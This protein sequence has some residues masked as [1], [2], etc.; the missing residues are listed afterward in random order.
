MKKIKLLLFTIIIFI[1]IFSCGEPPVNMPETNLIDLIKKNLDLLNEVKN[2]VQKSINYFKELTNNFNALIAFYKDSTITTS[3]DEALPNKED[4]LYTLKDNKFLVRR[5]LYVTF[6]DK[7]TLYSFDKIIWYSNRSDANKEIEGVKNDYYFN[8]K[9]DGNNIYVK[10]KMSFSVGRNPII[11]KLD[12]DRETIDL[13]KDMVFA[14]SQQEKVTADLE[15]KILFVPENTILDGSVNIDGNLVESKN[16]E[17]DFTIKALQNIYLY[18]KGISFSVSFDKKNWN[19]NIL[20]FDINP[21][22]E[23]Y[24]KDD[25]RIFFKVSATAIYNKDKTSFSIIKLLLG[26]RR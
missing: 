18:I 16:T 5:S 9:V 7:Q 2:D 17:S 3:S 21:N 14:S 24:A 26:S 8:S 19:P 25:N 12:K 10:Y 4:F 20:S 22:I 1:L 23:V 6:Q 11:V 15:N 13:K